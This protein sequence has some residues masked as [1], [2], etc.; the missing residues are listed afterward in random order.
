M[1][2]LIWT[3]ASARV[4]REKRPVVQTKPIGRRRGFAVQ[5]K[6]IWNS[7]AGVRGPIVQNEPNF[8]SNRNHHGGTETPARPSAGTKTYS[9]Q[10]RQEG[11]TISVFFPL[12][13][14][15]LCA[16]HD[17][18]P[19]K[20]LCQPLQKNWKRLSDGAMR[21]THPAGRGLC[22]ACCTNKANSRADAWA[23]VGQTPRSGPRTDCAERSQFRR[24]LKWEV[25]SLKPEGPPAALL[26]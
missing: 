15:R 10:E 3:P 2:R 19:D 6:P 9:R 11:E 5:T 1:R 24:S 23:G 18:L 25:W 26:A 22:R 21:G 17:F 13:S 8:G 16:R 14:L 4:T 7:P 20:N 12:R